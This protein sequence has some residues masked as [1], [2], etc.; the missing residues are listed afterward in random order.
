VDHADISLRPGVISDLAASIALYERA[1]TDTAILQGVQVDGPIPSDEEIRVGLEGERKQLIEFLATRPGARWWVCENEVGLVGYARVV[2]FGDVEE[3][4]ELMVERDYRGRGLGRELLSR[5]WPGDEASSA[6]RVVV[7]VGAPADLTLY[8]AFGMHPVTGHWHLRASKR[9]FIA[10]C[11]QEGQRDDPRIVALASDEARRAW[12][13]LEPAALGLDRPAVHEFFAS[14]RTCLAL[15][16]RDEIASVCWA[17]QDGNVGPA[18]GTSPQATADVV[19]EA[20]RRAAQSLATDWIGVF[21]TTA[22]RV[23]YQR[24]RTLGFWVHWPSWVMSSASLPV[25]DRY[26][27]TRPPYIL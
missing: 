17:D 8:S 18:V 19:V 22:N 3:L 27:P 5:C 1:I 24:L 4:T 13:R 23:L 9:P 12:R 2:Q 7:A 11:A 14:T 25:L 26:V 6:Q 15:L 10:A 16:D 21:C 20:L